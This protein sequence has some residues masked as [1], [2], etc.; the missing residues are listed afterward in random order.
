[1]WKVY[2][3]INS[4]KKQVYHGVALDIPVRITKSH[5]VGATKALSHWDCNKHKITWRK[6]SQHRSQTM[7]SKVSH[8]LEKTYKNY[9]GFKN[10]KT[11]GI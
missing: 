2:R 7:A 1:M 6:V 4:T 8:D 11:A 9:K 10:I 5:C 3:G